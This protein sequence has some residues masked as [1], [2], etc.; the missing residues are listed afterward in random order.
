MTQ[1]HA[2]TVQLISY[3]CIEIVLDFLNISVMIPCSLSGYMYLLL[4]VHDMA[5]NKT[6]IFSLLSRANS[7]IANFYIWYID[8]LLCRL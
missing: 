5:K 3:S 8:F 2:L 6:S 7:F 1:I 4:T